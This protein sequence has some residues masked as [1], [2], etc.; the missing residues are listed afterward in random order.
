MATE[1]VVVGDTPVEEVEVVRQRRVPYVSYDARLG[2][3]CML[4]TMIVGLGIFILTI[5]IWAL[6]NIGTV[7]R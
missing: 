7:F 5:L 2:V 4:W 1:E 6:A 3:S